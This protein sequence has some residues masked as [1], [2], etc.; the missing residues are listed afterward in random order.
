MRDT[1]VPILEQ[2]RPHSRLCAESQLVQPVTDHH[3][4][5]NSHYKHIA[6]SLAARTNEL[7]EPTFIHLPA[8]AS[9]IRFGLLCN[10]DGQR[11]AADDVFDLAE[12]CWTLAEVEKWD[13]KKIAAELGWK[14]DIQVWQ[15]KAIREKLHDKAWQLARYGLTRN[16]PLV[17]QEE[18]DL[19]SP[20]L[21]K[22]SWAE[23]HFR[24]FLA[25]LSYKDGDR[26]TMRAQVKAIR[27]LLDAGMDK[28]V[29]QLKDLCIAIPA[30]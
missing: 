23:T 17:R 29:K 1:T 28:V 19:V 12:L 7:T 13:G 20:E 3:I 11:T 5:D 26:A 10:A 6:L 27:E 21:T 8:D 2:T 24:S 22:V 16:T 18:N 9:P 4:K 14:T 25:A 30:N 15:H